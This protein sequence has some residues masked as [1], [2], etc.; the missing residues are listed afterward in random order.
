MNLVG[1]RRVSGDDGEVVVDGCKFVENDRNLLG[2]K[3]SW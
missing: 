1:L 3:W 2:M